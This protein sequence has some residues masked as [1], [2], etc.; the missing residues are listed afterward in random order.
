[1][2]RRREEEEEEGRGLAS[3][4][5]D[6]DSTGESIP[7]V[8]RRRLCL[9]S[10]LCSQFTSDQVS[11]LRFYANPMP[12]SCRRWG[13]P[14][15]YVRGFAKKGFH[16]PRCPSFFPPPVPPLHVSSPSLLSFGD[17]AARSAFKRASWD[18]FYPDRITEL[19]IEPLFPLFPTMFQESFTR[20]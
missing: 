3:R 18:T 1:M 20:T 2:A 6:R 8:P 17:T 4:S 11:A 5:V 7:F 15:L 19:S 13:G 12:M 16:F 14:F 9:L 10:K